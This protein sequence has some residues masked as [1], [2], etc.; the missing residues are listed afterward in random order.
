LPETLK[1]R[2]E[3]VNVDIIFFYPQHFNRNVNGSNPY[4][5]CLFDACNKNNLSYLLIEEPDYESGFPRDNSALPFDFALLVIL[6]LRRLIPLRHFTSFE[7]REWY[8]GKFLSKH[9]YSKLVFKNFITISNSMLGIFKGISSEAKLFDYQHGIIDSKNEGYIH[10]NKVASHIQLNGA[11]ILVYGKKF[12]EILVK[13]DPD[14]YSVK[15]F[16]I[17]FNHFSCIQLHESLNLNVLIS[18]Q[19]TDSKLISAQEQYL[20]FLDKLFFSNAENLAQLGFRFYLKNHPRYDNSLNL[21]SRWNFPFVQ[22][23]DKSIDD[24]FELCSTH[25]TYHSTTTFEAARNGI[26]TFFVPEELPNRIFF[27]DFHYPLPMNDSFNNWLQNLKDESNYIDAA[28]KLMHWYSQFYEPF[29][30]N[31]FVNLLSLA[32]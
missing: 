6:I 14:Y 12:L 9:L 26:P 18:L 7:Q 5:R 10:N 17:G 13:A 4:F 29:N 11:N 20:N 8:I 28:E 22:F 1:F 31:K 19:F 30:E 25:L 27:D 24:C 2:K 21:E 15:S 32:R 16:A 23:T 3:K